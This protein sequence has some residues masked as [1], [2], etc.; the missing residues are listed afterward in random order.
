MVLRTCAWAARLRRV[1]GK[2]QK[3]AVCVLFKQSLTF[4]DFDYSK[5]NGVSC[6]HF[7]Q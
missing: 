6:W 1:S 7:P 5:T 2:M 3:N 4:T